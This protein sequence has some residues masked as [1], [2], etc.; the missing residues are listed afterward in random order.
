M[1]IKFKRLNDLA[2]V[3]TRADK[4]SAGYDLYCASSY[5]IQI[6]AHS[7]VKIGTG[8]CFE[9]PSGYW[10]GIYARSGI[11]AKR[12]LRPSNCVGVI[13]SSY[14]GEII[15]AFHNDSPYTRTVQ[16]GE[17]IAQFIVHKAYD[18]DFKEVDE[19]TETIRGTGGFASTGEK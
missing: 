8:L 13:D 11:A 19:L 15:V 18:L 14:R 10:G 9:I 16:A 1:E 2:K 3:P 5:D 7:T 4:G 6:P 12:N 17:R